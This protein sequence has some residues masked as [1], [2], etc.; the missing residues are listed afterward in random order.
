MRKRIGV[1][2]ALVIAAV[3]SM[4]SLTLVSMARTESVARSSAHTHNHLVS[5]FGTSRVAL[6]S[7]ALQAQ[8]PTSM[9][10][11]KFLPKKIDGNKNPE[12]ISTELA[13]RHFLSAAA[14]STRG[15]AV[16]ASRR[17][18]AYLARVAG[19]GESDRETLVSLLSNLN[20]KLEGLAAQRAANSPKQGMISADNKLRLTSIQ[21]A[22][23]ET[24]TNARF[25]VES[26]LSPSGRDAIAAFVEQMKRK[27]VVY[28][29]AP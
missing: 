23:R 14:A 25:D 18:D 5:H 4:T 27:I 21:I 1:A 2:A 13:Y 16:I 20:T 19:L 9:R 8:R 12:L 26:Q 28:S 15:P 29:D 10:S 24:L 17:R 7:S 11:T 6:R 3:V 22:E